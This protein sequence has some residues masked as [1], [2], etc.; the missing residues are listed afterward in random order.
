MVYNKSSVA[1]HI[2]VI[3]GSVADTIGALFVLNKYNMKV[4]VLAYENWN[5][6]CLI[7]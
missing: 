6:F 5:L 3:W 4:G 7:L 2:L 1:G